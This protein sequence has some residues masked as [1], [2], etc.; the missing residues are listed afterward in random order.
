MRE[1]QQTDFKAK[2]QKI[3]EEIEW[4]KRIEDQLNIES[5][6]DPKEK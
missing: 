2:Q 1:L 3:E 4:E 5:V 6:A